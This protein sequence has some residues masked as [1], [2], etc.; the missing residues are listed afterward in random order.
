[1]YKAQVLISIEGLTLTAEDIELIKH[2]ACAGIVLFS[3]NYA[4]LAQ[5]QQLTKQIKAIK[6]PVII[7]V[8]HEG[9]RVQRWVDGFTQLPPMAHWG[10][11]F[12]REPHQALLDLSH[13][14]TLVAEELAE[15]GVNMNLAPVL[16]LNRGVSDII[17]ERSLCNDPQTV[18]ELAQRIIAVMHRQRFPVVGKHFPGHGGV[19]ADSHL[20]LPVDER[21]EHIIFNE[22]MQPF[23]VLASQLDVIMPAHIRFPAVHEMPVTYSTYWL[24][25]VLREQIGFQGVIMTD[26]LSMAGAASVGEPDVRA[27][28]AV[29]AG[30]ELLTICNDRPAAVAILDWLA[31]NAQG[32][33]TRLMQLLRGLRT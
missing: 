18:I 12:I 2:P 13:T 21:P 16:D 9:G 32:E 27:E 30:A 7:S 29:A 19:K 23:V 31:H 26:C 1:M 14:M 8:D 24:Q 6:S 3:R 10:L 20:A 33:N 25:T 22:D 17:G 5:L 15:V 28:L 4:S 11:E